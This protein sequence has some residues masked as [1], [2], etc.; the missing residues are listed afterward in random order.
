MALVLAD[1]VERADVRMLEA[2]DVPRFALEPLAPARHRRPD[3][4]RQHLDGDEAIEPRVARLVDLAHAAFADEGEDLVGTEPG[5]GGSM[6]D[7]TKI[8]RSG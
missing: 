1:V 4:G 8:T 7:W 3:A 5:A 6:S 2:R